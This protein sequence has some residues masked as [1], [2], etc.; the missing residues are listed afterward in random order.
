MV[1]AQIGAF[2]MHYETPFLHK[3]YKKSIEFYENYITLFCL[4]KKT[5]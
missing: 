3:G 1:F 4:E 2:P 5:C